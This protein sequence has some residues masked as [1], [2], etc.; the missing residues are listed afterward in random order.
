MDTNLS[1]DEEVAT[2]T[3]M[4][5]ADW[6]QCGH[7]RPM[8]MKLESLCCK[9]EECVRPL[10]PEEAGCITAHLIFS[11]ACMKVHTLEVAYY[12]LMNDH[13]DFLEASE[14]HRRYRYT[15]YR[16]FALWVWRRLGRKKRVMLPSCVGSAIMEAFPSQE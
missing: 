12:A 4:G 1:S 14:I 9:E 5:H 11:Q 10:I 3:R 7:C 13:P 2:D 16:Q 15:T 8:E 6:C